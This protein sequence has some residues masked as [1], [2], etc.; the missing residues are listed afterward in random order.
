MKLTTEQI[1]KTYL[2][3]FGC[4]ADSSGFEYWKK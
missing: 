1:Q 3:T 2:L 4:N